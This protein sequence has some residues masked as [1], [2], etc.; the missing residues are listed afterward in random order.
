MDKVD[1]VVKAGNGG[2]GVVSFRR[3]K[4]MPLGGPDGGDGGKGG[5]IFI[6]ADR[7]INTLSLF[8]HK[9]IFKAE[10]G[11]GGAEKKKHGKKG[12]DLEI[13]VPLGTSVHKHEDNGKLFLA[14]LCQQ[15]QVALVARGGRGGLGN[16]HFATSTDQAPQRITYGIPGEE[17]RLS[18]DLQLIADVGIIGY[19]SVG[20][21]TLLSV[22]SAAKP[23]TADY[24]FTTLEPVLG[25]VQLGKR[26]FIMA[27]IPGLIEG[28]HIGKGLG[29]DFLRHAE[30]TKLLLHLLD[31][32]SSNP[33][34]QMHRLNRELELYKPLLARKPQIVAVN[35]I[36]LLENPECISEIEEVLKENGI[37]VY[38]ISG[39]S[40]Q[41]V[42]ELIVA[43]ADELDKIGEDKK[44]EMEL[45]FVVFRPM[46]KKGRG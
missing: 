37:L 17:I 32:T 28:A 26:N 34:E 39:L 12:G 44:E 6:R 14:D 30:R 2:N 25:E 27:E 9:R 18:L 38:F 19:P 11:K 16:A 24:P 3:E 45:P 41:G 31:G 21:S 1:I 22:V 23:K 42:S 13:K 33:I 15:G 10:S 43:I 4:Y 36:D 40:R 7:G 20:K 35:K 5:D 8:R 46:P 29:H